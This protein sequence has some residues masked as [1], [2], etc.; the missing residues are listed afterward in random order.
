MSRDCPIR[1]KGEWA[2]KLRGFLSGRHFE[3]IVW[4]QEA[5]AVFFFTV[6]EENY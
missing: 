1:S 2:K 6:G 4:T 5:H 3:G